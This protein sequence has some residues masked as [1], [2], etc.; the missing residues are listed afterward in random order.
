[1]SLLFCHVQ[2]LSDIHLVPSPLQKERGVC[3][4]AAATKPTDAPGLD[5]CSACMT[6]AVSSCFA[7]AASDGASLAEEMLARDSQ[8]EVGSQC[9]TSWPVSGCVYTLPI[10]WDASPADISGHRDWSAVTMQLSRTLVRPQKLNGYAAGHQLAQGKQ[11]SRLCTCTAAD[12][13][14]QAYIHSYL[15]FTAVSAVTAVANTPGAALVAT[16]PTL[17]S[18]TLSTSKLTAQSHHNFCLSFLHLLYHVCS[19]PYWCIFMTRTNKPQR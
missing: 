6:V 19:I 2:V 1:M 8:R 10:T 14:H 4:L 17:S 7:E 5:V 12:C 18:K 16:E 15:P 9:R 11:R 3:W 13:V